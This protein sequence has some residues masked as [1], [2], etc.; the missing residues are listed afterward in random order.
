MKLIF[1]I[2]NDDDDSKKVSSELSKSG[3]KVTKLNSTGGFLR[4]GNTTFLI[5]VEDNKVDEVI[6]IIKKNSK[7]RKQ[8]ITYSP[9]GTDFNI[10]GNPEYCY[11]TEPFTNLSNIYNT[12]Y[13]YE[14]IVVGSTIFVTNA[15]TF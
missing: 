1:A 6:E 4:T 2:V 7:S 9:L 8:A 14:F 3:F 10:S 13:V 15:I 5:G 11:N 12:P